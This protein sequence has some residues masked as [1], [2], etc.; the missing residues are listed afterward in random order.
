MAD[1]LAFLPHSW[2]IALTVI[3]GLCIGSFLNVLVHRLPIMMEQDFRHEC[4]CLDQPEPP[5]RSQAYNLFTP[6]SACPRCGHAIGAAENIPV[7]SWLM[8]KGRC[9]NC[10]NPISARYPLVESA[11]GIVAGL[12]AWQLGPSDL[13]LPSLLFVWILLALTLI[14]LDHFLLPDSLTLGLLWLGLA[15]NLTGL[16]A[17]LPHAVIGAIAGYG[18]LWSVYWLFKLLTGKE[19][20]GYGDFKLLAALGA[21]LGWQSLPAMLLLASLSGAVIGIGLALGQRKS[22]RNPIP[23]GPYLAAAGLIMMFAG[24]QV[25]GLLFP[26]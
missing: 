8:L 5:A 25:Q 10:K 22:L 6:R 11:C 21:W 17:P 13:L 26:L 9:K 23:F 24:K 4:A 16:F 2:F 18:L 15:F 12:L 7:I 19:G 14:D 3:V 20:M 1:L